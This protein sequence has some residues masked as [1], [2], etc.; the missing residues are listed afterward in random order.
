MRQAVVAAIPENDRELIRAEGNRQ[1]DLNP[2]ASRARNQL[3]EA[4]QGPEPPPAATP[5]PI[6]AET[7]AVEQT[8][9]ESLADRPQPTRAAKLATLGVE[10][11]PARD[12]IYFLSSQSKELPRNFFSPFLLLYIV[13]SARVTKKGSKV[14]SPGPKG[15][16]Q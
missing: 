6:E 10:S 9:G 11:D 8:A 1:I 2:F 12:A 5:P 16:E 15:Q 4:P 3:L 13:Q 7:P 14:T